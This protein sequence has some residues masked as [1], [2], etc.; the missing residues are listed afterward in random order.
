MCLGAHGRGVPVRRPGLG[1]CGQQR[2]CRLRGGMNS[3]VRRGVQLGARVFPAAEPGCLVGRRHCQAVVAAQYCGPHGWRSARLLGVPTGRSGSPGV[4]SRCGVAGSSSA[5]R[6][7]WSTAVA[8]GRRPGGVRE[9]W[10]LVGGF[11]ESYFLYWED[12]DLSWRIVA[13]G[14]RLAVAEDLTAFHAVGATQAGSTKSATYVYYS[15]RNRL[16]FAGTLPARTR[17]GLA[18]R[19]ATYHMG[20]DRDGRTH[21]SSL[22]RRDPWGGP[23]HP[24]FAALASSSQ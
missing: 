13:A 8:H 14:G 1:P 5:R 2:Q 21:P 15:A 24:V 6:D 3:G 23:G 22:P 7:R 16:R 12:V 9:L 20:A 11:D 19:N 18:H 17:S 4:R 10:D